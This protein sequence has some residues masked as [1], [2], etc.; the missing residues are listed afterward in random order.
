L[1]DTLC[2]FIVLGWKDPVAQTGGQLGCLR[3]LLQARLKACSGYLEDMANIQ[4]S[5][6]L[7]RVVNIIRATLIHVAEVFLTD[8]HPTTF[9]D[10][11]IRSIQSGEATGRRS[12]KAHSRTLLMHLFDS[13]KTNIHLIHRYLPENLQKFTHDLNLSAAEF[14]SLTNDAVASEVRAWVDQVGVALQNKG[15]ARLKQLINVRSLDS[16]KSK[17]WAFLQA[18]EYSEDKHWQ[19][20]RRSQPNCWCSKFYVMLSKLMI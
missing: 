8:T 9:I 10:D 13:S 3:G 18:D 5:D 11:V 14:E 7:L 20:V 19:T 1:S 16:I 17:I 4:T 12:P 15:K 6:A 2:C